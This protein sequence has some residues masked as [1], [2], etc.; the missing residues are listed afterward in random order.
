[1]VADK[2]IFAK[3]STK[4]ISMA[5]QLSLH[6]T[7]HNLSVF[8]IVYKIHQSFNK[9]TWKRYDH[10]YFIWLDAEGSGDK[11]WCWQQAGKGGKHC[12]MLRETAKE[13]IFQQRQGENNHKYVSSQWFESQ[14]ST[15]AII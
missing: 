14:W 6:S 13:C 15:S 8:L 12:K 9:I 3:M 11:I 10:Y 4:R 1:M 2:T 7:V 5:Q